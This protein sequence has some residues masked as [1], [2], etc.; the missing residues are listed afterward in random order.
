ML[1]SG[2]TRDDVLYYVL[3]LDRSDLNKKTGDFTIRNLQ[4]GDGNVYRVE[5]NGNP[6][7]HSI[8]LN[9]LCKSTLALG[10][11]SKKQDPN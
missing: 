3:L 10:F 1:T 11:A 4:Y 8:R 6:G 7:D 2:E 9:V 5:I